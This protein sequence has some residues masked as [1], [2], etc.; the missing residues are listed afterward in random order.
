MHFHYRLKW[1]VQER[2]GRCG[3]CKKCF[4]IG[5]KVAGV[6]K[7]ASGVSLRTAGNRRTSK[8]TC[9]RSKKRLLTDFLLVP[10][11]WPSLRFLENDFPLDLFLKFA[12]K[13]FF[14]PQI[15]KFARNPIQIHKIAKN[16]PNQFGNSNFH[17]SHLA[18][19]PTNLLI[20]TN[21]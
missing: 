1:L 12:M 19:I 11:C 21:I 18:V 5:L 16:L 15:Q 6:S 4:W 14:Y 2:S 8:K 9:R 7:N 13:T 3:K 10:E 17:A 20:C